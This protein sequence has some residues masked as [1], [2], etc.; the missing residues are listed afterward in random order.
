MPLPLPLRR[1]FTYEPPPAA[2]LNILYQDDDLIFIDKP[3]GLLSVPG[4]GP[5]KADCVVSRLHALYDDALLVHRLDVAT[6]GVM[7]FARNPQA[8]RHLG[9]QFE[10]RYTQKIY[11]AHIAGHIHGESGY[12]NLPLCADWPY[13]PR[14]MVSFEHGKPSTTHWIKN[15]QNQSST[16]V[17]L[18]P[19]TGRSHQLRVHMWAMG[20]PILGDRIYAPD[21]IFNATDRLCLHAQSLTVRRPNG[22]EPI[23]ITSPCP[24]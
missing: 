2:P 23:S 16:C 18:L 11:T 8:Q 9:L 22:G 17:S 15:D 4:K 5:D 10:K 14:Q 24:F 19:I 13:R 20:H 6:S 12:V 7:I 21:N 1:D 3:A